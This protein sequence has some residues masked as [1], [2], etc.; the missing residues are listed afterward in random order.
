MIQ[1][2]FINQKELDAMKDYIVNNKKDWSIDYLSMGTSAN[3]KYP[4]M[5]LYEVNIEGTMDYTDAFHFGQFLCAQKYDDT[6]F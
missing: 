4:D 2:C 5:R 1:T 6:I 3:D